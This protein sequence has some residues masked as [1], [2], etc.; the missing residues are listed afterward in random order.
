M[1][2]VGL[3]FVCARD[4]GDVRRVVFDCARLDPLVARALRLFD[5]KTIDCFLTNS[6]AFTHTNFWLFVLLLDALN[7][8]APLLT[9]LLTPQ[10][11]ARSLTWPT[12]RWLP[13]DKW[14]A[15]QRILA[16]PRSNKLK[17]TRHFFH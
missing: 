5:G 17:F 3:V 7:V 16:V 12:S 2:D 13:D 11:V 15:S 9:D 10:Q 4:S 14:L 8:D 6:V 1:T